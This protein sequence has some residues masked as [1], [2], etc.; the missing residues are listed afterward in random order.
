MTYDSD[1]MKLTFDV[2]DSDGGW[3]I[4]SSQ[5]TNFFAVI[6]HDSTTLTRSSPTTSTLTSCPVPTAEPSPVPTPVPYPSPTGVPVPSPS[7]SPTWMPTPVPSRYGISTKY[8]TV[9]GGRGR[10]NFT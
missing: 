9:R 4:S 10:Y 3:W 7:V 6:G 5:S 1:T 8:K 2:S